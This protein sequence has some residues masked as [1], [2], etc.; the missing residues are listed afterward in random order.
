MT[1]EVDAPPPADPPADPKQPAKPPAAAPKPPPAPDPKSQSPDGAPPPPAQAG[2]FG[3]WGFDVNAVAGNLGGLF[4]AADPTATDDVE[5]RP[6]PADP[7]DDMGTAAANIAT[8][9]TAELEHASKA[10]QQ[11][12]GKA[13][14]ELGKG[15]GS[16]NT[17]LDE[18][19]AAKPDES[20]PAEGA[21][22]HNTFHTLFPDLEPDDE[23]VDHFKCTL[24]QKYRCYLNNATP[25]KAYSL[26]GRLYVTTLHIAMYISDDGGEFGGKP[27]GISVP[28][29]D[30]GK[31]QKGS[32]S[33]LRV[34]TKSQTS[35][36]F[37]DFESDS[38]FS[39][40]LSLLEHMYA[41]ASA[42]PA[43]ASEDAAEDA[44]EAETTATG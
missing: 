33:M 14:E 44:T 4:T 2:V 32:K 21:D 5:P 17:F 28:F 10:A 16:L 23:V 19:L 6:G 43:P 15:W 29:T 42:P 37:A 25:E 13:A 41:S 36:I 24:L 1:G 27:F 18:M 3:G 35:L 11:T 22:V 34:V 38:H 20:D 7:A 30:V 8:A 26:R 12:F 39:G 9:A 31:I 40:A